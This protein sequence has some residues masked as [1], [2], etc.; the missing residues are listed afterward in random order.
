LVAC[1]SETELGE[2]EASEAQTQQSSVTKPA[3]GEVQD[4]ET[5]ASQAAGVQFCGEH[6]HSDHFQSVRSLAHI[7]VKALPS[8]VIELVER[9][10]PPLDEYEQRSV[11]NDQLR[12]RSS[13]PVFP[14]RSGNA[15]I[16]TQALVLALITT[17]WRDSWVI[18]ESEITYPCDST[19]VPLDLATDYEVISPP[20]GWEPR[21]PAVLSEP[22]PSELLLRQPLNSL[23][24]LRIDELSVLQ[25]ATDILSVIMPGCTNPDAYYNEPR[26]QH[27]SVLKTDLTSNSALPADLLKTVG[28]GSDFRRFEQIDAYQVDESRVVLIWLPRAG[29][30]SEILAVGEL[31]RATQTRGQEPAWQFA[32]YVEVYG[33]YEG[34]ERNEELWFSGRGDL[35]HSSLRTGSSKD[36][37]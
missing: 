29:Q 18:E 7:D 34:A 35:L 33:C 14:N 11:S 21:D 17:G 23:S 30:S 3:T 31:V 25:I 26:S 6:V 19:G 13:S 1:G 22:E 32:E 20:D 36:V 28:T 37:E 27:Q 9:D 8:A 12:L 16:V 15:L 10:G 2:S 4:P 24:E 5:D